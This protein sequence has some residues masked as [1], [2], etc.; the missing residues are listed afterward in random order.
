[1]FHSDPVPLALIAHPDAPGAA[2]RSIGVRVRAQ[3]GELRL[4]YV[5]A[6]D[7]ARVRLPAEARGG[8]ADGLWR[9]TCFEAFLGLAGSPGYLE[10]NFSPSGQWAAY[11][12]SGYRRDMTPLELASPPRIHARREGERLTLETSVSCGALAAHAASDR[13][14][15]AQLGLAAV[16]EEDSGTLSYW[17]LGHFGAR[18]DFHDRRAFSA[19]LPALQVHTP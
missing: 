1:M 19:G 6:G 9:H 2:V 12:F 16:V 18:P 14:A 17:A 7:L 13:P 4:E 11:R 3:A 10:L 5:M 15:A 8:R